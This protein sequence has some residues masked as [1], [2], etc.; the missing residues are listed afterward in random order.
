M[1]I[2]VQSVKVGRERTNCYVVREPAGDVVVIDPGAEPGLVLELIPAGSR[3]RYILL[4]HGHYDHVG[5]VDEIKKAFPDTP[6]MI[7]EEDV[8]LYSAVPEQ[9]VFVSELLPQPKAKLEVVADGELLPFGEYEIEVI[10]TPGHTPGGVCYL[11]EGSLFSGDTLFY[12]TVGRTDLPFSDK[13]KMVLSLDRLKHLEGKIV[14]YPGHGKT[15]TIAEE[16]VA[17]PYIS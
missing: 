15:T 1:D 6:V 14:V 3:L 9:G 2:N 13:Q 7:S 12:H 10:A 8:K 17:N 4:T 11:I 5:A 16:K